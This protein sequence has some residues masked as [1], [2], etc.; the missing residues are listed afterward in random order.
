MLGISPGRSKLR[1]DGGE[2]ISVG[3][4][5]LVLAEGGRI[6]TDFIES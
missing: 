4:D 3:F 1:V 2:V 6:R 5:F